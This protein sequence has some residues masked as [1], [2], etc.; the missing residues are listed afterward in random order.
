MKGVRHFMT[1]A[2]KVDLRLGQKQL[3]PIVP[4]CLHSRYIAF[5]NET[6]H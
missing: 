5:W 4:I 2:C 3:V 6:L 1:F